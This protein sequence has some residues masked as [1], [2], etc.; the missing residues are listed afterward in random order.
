[1]RRLTA[2]IYGL[3]TAVLLVYAAR[4][5]V[6]VRGELMDAGNRLEQLRSEAGA[7]RKENAELTRRLG[8]PSGKEDGA[9]PWNAVE[10]DSYP[11]ADN[12]D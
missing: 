12:A 6:I 9:E 4:R 8:R 1:M 11:I 10:E 7:L 2:W 3:L 5:V